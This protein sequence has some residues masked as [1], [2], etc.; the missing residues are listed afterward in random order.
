M[1]LYICLLMDI[2]SIW[3]FLAKKLDELSYEKYLV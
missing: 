2:S 1:T 3:D